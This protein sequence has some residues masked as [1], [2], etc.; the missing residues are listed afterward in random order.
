MYIQQILN[1]PIEFGLADTTLVVVEV[2]AED[3]TH[4]AYLA[5]GSTT[6]PVPHPVIQR[7]ADDTHVRSDE[8]T[9]II[10]RTE[11]YLLFGHDDGNLGMMRT[12]HAHGF[13]PT[14]TSGYYIA[15]FFFFEPVP[16]SNV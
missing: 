11:L 10:P 6:M 12:H 5:L 16:F 9:H 13:S 7:T 2:M 8:C 14:K 3:D 4:L 15:D 1:Q